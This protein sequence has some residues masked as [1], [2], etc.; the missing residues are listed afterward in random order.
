[1]FRLCV[2]GISIAVRLCFPSVS[3]VSVVF[4]CCFVVAAY[5]LH[6]CFDCVLFMFRFVF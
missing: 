1:M 2:V 4:R 3:C 5:A 6:L